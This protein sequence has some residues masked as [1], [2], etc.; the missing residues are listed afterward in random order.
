MLPSSEQRDPVDRISLKMPPSREPQICF[1]SPQDN[2][3][4]CLKRHRRR[5]NACNQF[6]DQF[7]SEG[8]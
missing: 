8:I 7:V 3:V 4:S 1:I 2:H 5:E 6:G